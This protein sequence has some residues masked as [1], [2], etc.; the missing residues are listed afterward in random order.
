MAR[1][2]SALILRE[3]GSRD[4]RASLGFLW[5]VIEPLVS[6]AILSVLFSLIRTSPPLGTNFALYYVT[7]VIPFHLYSALSRQI[8]RSMRFSRNLL[9]L[10]SVTVIDVISARIRKSLV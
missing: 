7:G 1:V 3:T 9:G 4:S 10:P 8:A 5:N 2:V 6:I